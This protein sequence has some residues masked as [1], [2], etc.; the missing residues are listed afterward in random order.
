MISVCASLIQDEE[1]GVI[2]LIS[3]KA[4]GNAPSTELTRSLQAEKQS[5]YQHC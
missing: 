3:T 5:K 2:V 4:F 1:G